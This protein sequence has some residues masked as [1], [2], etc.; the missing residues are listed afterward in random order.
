MK[1]FLDKKIETYCI[2]KSTVSSS[3]C[4]AIEAYTE[5]HVDR[6]QMLIG[7]LEG[8]FLGFLVS[9]IKAKNVLEIG[10]FTGY[11]A[12]SIAERLPKNGKLIS[13]DIDEET[14]RIARQFW[15]KSPH[16][17]KIQTIL[18]PAL[19]SLKKIKGPFDFIFID[20]DKH[21]YLK[22]LKRCLPLLNSKGLIAVDNC[23]WGGD[24]LKTSSDPDTQTIQKL[25]DYVSHNK[26]LEGFLAPI[27]DGIFL[28]Q[29][30]KS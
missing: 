26:N 12:L 24:V 2:Q 5:K 9:L 30:K 19:D 7:E 20:A 29:K 28:I 4:K 23:L 11:S 22:Y 8:S 1:N 14:N 16:G 15:K 13:L 27:R 21:N 6:A 25:N 17:Y 18:G 10:C 3:H